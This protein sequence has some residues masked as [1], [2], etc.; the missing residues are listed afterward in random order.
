MAVTKQ[1]IA[2]QLRKLS[3][4]T[5]IWNQA[6]V[7]ELPHIIHEGERISECVNGL[8]EGGVALLVATEMR[9]LLID[10]KPLNYLNVEDL[11]FDMINEIDYNH[12]LTMASI[13]VSTGSKTL[14]FKSFNQLRL[15]HLISLVQEHMTNAK[16]EPVTKA[17]TQ[18]QHLEE[19]NKQLRL[20]LMAQQ[21]Q[22]EKL[23]A[24]VQ[25]DINKPVG[26]LPKAD[27]KLTDYLLAQ[28]LLENFEGGGDGTPPPPTPKIVEAPE[29]P[30]DYELLRSAKREV[31]SAALRGL[32]KLSVQSLSAGT[33]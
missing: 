22:L 31:F 5:T 30:E 11:R 28:R 7:A 25:N 19:I 17:A 6:E 18:Q 23:H 32:G 16:R 27:P 8:Y 3:F 10:K 21:E 9:L 26:D 1:D 2:D 33:A 29:V 14:R 15:R 4:S 24:H 20:Y 13:T 12:R